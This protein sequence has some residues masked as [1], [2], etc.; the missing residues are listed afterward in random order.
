ML[1]NI[2]GISYFYYILFHDVFFTICYIFLLQ[3]TNPL[4]RSSTSTFKN[5]A[6]KHT[7]R[8]RDDLC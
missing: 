4:F 1:K 3:G 2:N 6:Y 7:V 8:Q 5:V